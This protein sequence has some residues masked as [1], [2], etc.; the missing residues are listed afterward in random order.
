MQY[1][2][3][4]TKEEFKERLYPIN[5]KEE[6]TTTGVPLM[7]EDDTMY[8][9]KGR[10]HTLLIGATGSGKTQTTILPIINLSIKAKESFFVIDPKGELY[11]KVGKKLKEE[12]YKTTII[13]LENT[14]LGNNWNPLT[15]AYQVYK[16]GNKDK[17]QD[18]IEEVGYYLFENEKPNQSDPFW[19]NATTGYFEGLVLYLFENYQEKEINLTNIAKLSNKIE[20]EGSKEFLNKLNKNSAIYLNL[21]TTLNA[22]NETKGSILSIFQQKIKPFISRENLSNLLSTTDTSF[23][24]IVKEK[25][26]IFIICGLSEAGNRLIPLYI[27][28]LIESKYL[29]GDMKK[30]FNMLLDEFCYM[31]KMKNFTTVTNLARGLNIQMTIV[32]QNYQQLINVYGKEETEI[33]KLCFGNILYLL[34]NDIYS[35]EE[36]SKACGEVSN[37]IP[38]ITVEELK[39]MKHFEAIVLMT[40]MYPYRTKLTPNYK[41]DWGYETEEIEI[42]K[43]NTVEISYIDE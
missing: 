25:S 13:D 11:K 12:G 24:D 33:L 17:A 30:P 41:L 19:I 15:L 22:P 35:L 5:Q 10:N 20:E 39:T 18:L 37:N 42:P 32:V 43:R 28:Q 6:V 9:D 29:Y 16:E 31:L 2:R 27:N 8:I 3:W 26:A 21:V 40:R 1:A 38:L 14:S 23:K 36:I 34:S 7:Y 4:A